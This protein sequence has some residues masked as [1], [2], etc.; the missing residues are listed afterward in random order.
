VPETDQTVEVMQI[1]ELN[2]DQRREAVNTRQRFDAWRIAKAR[3]DHFRG[4]M[5]WASDN[6]LEYLVR[7]AYDP[8]TGLRRQK[9]LGPR[10]PDTENIKVKFEADRD[11]ARTRIAEIEQVLDRQ[12]SINRAI[13]LGRMPMIGAR[14]VRALDAAGLLGKGIRIVGTNAIYAYE[15]T[16]GVLIDAELVSTEDIDLLFDARAHLGLAAT[17]PVSER[18]LMNV[19]RKVDRSFERDLNTFRAI[20]RDGYLVDLIKPAPVPPWKK[21]PDTL[22]A[23]PDGDLIAAGIEGL[24]WL[25]NSPA[26]EAVVIDEQG[27]PLRLISPDPRAFAI[28]KLWVSQRQDRAA[29]KR[30]RDIGQAEVA[31]Q[32][33]ARYLTHLPYE[34]AMR[35]FPRD[36]VE[37]A[38]PLF[39][40]KAPHP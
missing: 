15:A 2:N 4:S 14:I 34:E 11:E 31:A 12:A 3:L 7:S 17:L 35:A 20:N 27:M 38:K 37:K 39:A 16:A 9:S 6:G 10:R 24:E 40:A 32:I 18:S 26:F 5:T 30:K 25:Q 28:H 19:L 36:L 33:V 21:E 1:Q 23:A 8:D 22:S 29:L 13:G